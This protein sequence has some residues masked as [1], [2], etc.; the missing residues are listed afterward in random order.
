MR[1]YPGIQ[2]LHAGPPVIPR[3]EF[4]AGSHQG[5]ADTVLLEHRKRGCAF[6]ALSADNRSG[7]DA[8]SL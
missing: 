3:N 6:S 2:K 4:D 1:F 7:K 5:P 8:R